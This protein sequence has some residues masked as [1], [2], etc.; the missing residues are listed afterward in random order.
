MP[1]P[2]SPLSPAGRQLGLFGNVIGQQG[3]MQAEDEETRR[4]R[5]LAQ[6]QQRFSPAMQSILG[7]RI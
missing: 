2:S 6:Q 7:Y 3:N 5:L 4:K 1:M